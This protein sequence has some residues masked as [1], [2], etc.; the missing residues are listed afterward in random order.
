MLTTRTLPPL[1]PR[2]VASFALNQRNA[3]SGGLLVLPHCPS[4]AEPLPRLICRPVIWQSA[5]LDMLLHKRH[6]RREVIQ[7]G[8]FSH[9]AFNLLPTRVNPEAIQS[10]AEA[11]PKQDPSPPRKSRGTQ[12]VTRNLP[13]IPNRKPPRSRQLHGP[14]SSPRSKQPTWY[15]AVP[16][17]SNSPHVPALPLVCPGSRSS[18]TGPLCRMFLGPWVLLGFLPQPTDQIYP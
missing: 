15:S 10:S 4:A 18:V 13:I 11:P 3:A 16:T 14:N 2:N 12:P 9:A 6:I 8:I 1:V 17:A 5:R 7:R